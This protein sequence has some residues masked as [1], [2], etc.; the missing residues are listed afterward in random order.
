MK[1]GKDKEKCCHKYGHH[2]AGGSM[3]FCFGF[4][5]ALVYFL[6]QATTLWEGILGIGKA[7]AWP[8]FLIYR[9]LGFLG[10]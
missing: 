10:L 6:Q 3:V 9:F 8:A 1:K 2:K 7:I 5:G 4:I